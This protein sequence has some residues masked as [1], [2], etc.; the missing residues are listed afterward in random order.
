MDRF[1]KHFY[2]IK[3]RDKKLPIGKHFNLPEH[4]GIEDVEIHILDFIHAPPDS[5]KAAKLWDLIEKNWILGL[6]SFA[7]FGINTMDIKNIRDP[8]RP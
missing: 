1:V 6:R 2:G 7:P 4:N 8:T 3:K 5:M